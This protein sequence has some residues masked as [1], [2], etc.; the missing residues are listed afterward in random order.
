MASVL[1]ITGHSAVLLDL[2]QGLDILRCVLGG[3]YVLLLIFLKKKKAHNKQLLARK[4][5]RSP[6]AKDEAS[7]ASHNNSWIF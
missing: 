7:A 1:T 2:L 3:L 6:E 4:L 5:S